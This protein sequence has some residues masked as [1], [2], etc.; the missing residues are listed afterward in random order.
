MSYFAEIPSTVLVASISLYS[1]IPSF[2]WW[3][4]RP[5]A[6]QN[7]NIR[8]EPVSTTNLRFRYLFRSSLRSF[9]VIYVPSIAFIP[10]MFLRP[11]ELISFMFLSISFLYSQFPMAKANAGC[12]A[13][14][15][16]N[17]CPLQNALSFHFHHFYPFAF[18]CF[19][20]FLPA[21]FDVYNHLQ[22]YSFKLQI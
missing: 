17:Q 9:P 15:G 21:S 8:M 18:Y 10:F 5:T 2:V 1:W 20:H 4:Q 12:I 14:W 16:R 3:K 13:K 7:Y 6:L 11:C 22:A 19:V